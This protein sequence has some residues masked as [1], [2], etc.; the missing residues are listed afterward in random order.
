MGNSS[1]NGKEKSNIN[2]N[3]NSNNINSENSTEKKENKKKNF[4]SMFSCCVKP[5]DIDDNRMDTREDRIR[6][7]MEALRRKRNKEKDKNNITFQDYH[8]SMDDI[9]NMDD[10]TSFNNANQNFSNNCKIKKD[11]E[12]KF[13]S[14]S[15]DSHNNTNN[16]NNNN[17]NTHINSEENKINDVVIHNNMNKSK[18]EKQVKLDLPKIQNINVINTIN[19]ANTLKT[20]LVD[21]YLKKLIFE[22][23][24]TLS[25]SILDENLIPDPSVIRKD[26]QHFPITR[27]N[28][29][30]TFE[31]WLEDTNFK[32][33]YKKPNDVLYVRINTKGSIFSKDFYLGYHQYSIDI[34]DLPNIGLAEVKALI[35]NPKLQCWDKTV[36][37][38]EL[39]KGDFKSFSITKKHFYSP[40]LI[41]TERDKV[42]KNVSFNID[43]TLFSFG[44]SVEEGEYAELAKDIIRLKVFVSLY[45]IRI[46]DKEN[47]ISKKSS[48]ILGDKS[49]NT[50]RKLIISGFNQIDCKSVLPE[51]IFSL[52]IPVKVKEWYS[53]FRKA[54]EIYNNN[55]EEGILNTFDKNNKPK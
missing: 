9:D 42:E 27:R 21:F 52:T 18:L 13:P 35:S 5:V 3:N 53:C 30:K 1:I 4:F 41:I 39:L 46:E 31:S 38:I 50:S 49:L 40:I 36:K 44:S 43:D 54:L 48:S 47:D 10:I 22:K 14:S 55:G 51:W 6:K 15:F 23:L 12:S 33:L 45:A 17:R 8:N 26:E 7:N 37:N 16:N 19:T 32:D 34:S 29:L 2:C 24:N 20:P 25:E 11:K 28:I